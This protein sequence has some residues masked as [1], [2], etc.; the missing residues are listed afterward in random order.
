[1]E[2]LMALT[3]FTPVALPPMLPQGLVMPAIPVAAPPSAPPADFKISKDFD[4][5]KWTAEDAAAVVLS[6]YKEFEVSQPIGAVPTLIGIPDELNLSLANE[7]HIR[8]SRWLEHVH[9]RIVRVEI[10]HLLHE[11]EASWLLKTMKFKYK[12][13]MEIGRVP[14]V[15]FERLR[16]VEIRALE[17]QAELLG[18]SAVKKSLEEVLAAASRTITRHVKA[19]PSLSA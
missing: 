10:Q 13:K 7:L 19:N 5:G 3:P 2:E 4:F 9:T 12:D 18:I 17:L 6:K 1:M 16:R 8:A 14:E 11:G 15:E